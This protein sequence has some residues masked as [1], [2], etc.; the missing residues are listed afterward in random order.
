MRIEAIYPLYYTRIP[1]I[2]EISKQGSIPEGNFGLWPRQSIPEA[3]GPVSVPREINLN[4]PPVEVT[5]SPEGW[6]AY[7]R[8]KTE[9][10]LNP[11][12]Q[13][14]ASQKNGLPA[15]LPS[16]KG[17]G[18]P[19]GVPKVIFKDN[20]QDGGTKEIGD[21]FKPYECQTCKNRKYQD[22]SSDPSVS[23]QS[24]THIAPNQAGAAVAS[25][26]SEHV[27]H[28]QAK[29]EREGRKIVSQTV[30]LSTSICPECGRIYISGGVT[31]TITANK[32]DII[33]EVPEETT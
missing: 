18:S 30:S 14:E 21:I 31:R 29:A 26:E 4:K 25:H 17:E 32:Q 5:I 24:P 3:A 23:Y 20:A 28:E 19:P 11:A 22:S 15:T 2:T 10:A 7:G 9:P 6:A 16:P 27:A 8:Y 13:T 12:A 1:Q 33:P